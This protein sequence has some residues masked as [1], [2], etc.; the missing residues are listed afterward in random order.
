MAEN[1]TQRSGST[2]RAASGPA[3]PSSSR[4]SSVQYDEFG[5]PITSGWAGWVVFAGVMLI[6]LGFFQAVEGLVA[7]FRDG[8]YAVRPSGL[9]VHA[10]YTTWGWT[11]LVIGVVALLTGIGLL[12]G[13]LL[14]RVVGVVLAV[15]SAIVNF[16]FI[17]AAPVWAAVVITVDVLV[18]YA[19]VAHGG[20]LQRRS[21]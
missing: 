13:N 16:A 8:Y 10:D 3:S 1:R 12:S 17:A 21:R 6:V 20:E 18:V 11:H 2:V 4:P 9:V 5:R 7:L 19:I 15:V 14:A